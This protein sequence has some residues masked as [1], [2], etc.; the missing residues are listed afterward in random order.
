MGNRSGSIP[1]GRQWTVPCCKRQRALK[2]T[3]AEG[4]GRN[5][6]DRGRSGSKL[7][8]HVDGQGIPLGVVVVGAN[9][10]DSHLIG[11][12]LENSCQMGAWFLGA[13]EAH[14]CLDRAYD[15]E[16]VHIE[17]Y[18]N[19]FTA[20]IRGRGE[21]K[22]SEHPQ[23]TPRRWVVER[24]FAWLRGFRGLRTRYCCYLRNFIGLVSL[25]CACIILRKLP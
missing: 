13:Q 1:N 17:V 14:L 15:C 12:T 9:V 4:L 18:V 20:H 10:H 25:A 5:P 3:A 19:G 8:L 11:A 21:E 7:H 16:R 23:D 6:T 24:T 2:K 22:S